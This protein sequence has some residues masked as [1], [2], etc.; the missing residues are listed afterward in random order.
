MKQTK[1]IVVLLICLCLMLSCIF[2][3]A[4]C[5]DTCSH[6]ETEWVVVKE[7]TA[8]EDGQK[9]EVCK[10]CD[11]ILS[12]DKIFLPLGHSQAIL[13]Q[14]VDCAW[15]QPHR[16][17]AGGTY[18]NHHQRRNGTDRNGSDGIIPRQR[19]F[20]GLGHTQTV[21]GNPIIAKNRIFPTLR[22]DVYHLSSKTINDT[23]RP[24]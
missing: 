3:L 21:P 7:A 9:N 5:N 17:Q 14:I 6:S 8:T 13:P 12:T 1:K 15:L 23:N 18:A 11:E 4:S 2:A 20:R 10:E 22:V 16:F 24:K 19:Q